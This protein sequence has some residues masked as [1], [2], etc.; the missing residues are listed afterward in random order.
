MEAFFNT[1][2]RW[3]LEEGQELALL[4]L[5]STDEFD[6]LLLCGSVHTRSRD[7]DT[8][9]RRVLLISLGLEALFHKDIEAE[10]AWLRCPR[11]ELGG[12][13][14]LDHMVKGDMVQLMTVAEIVKRER[15]L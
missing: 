14:P 15:G 10:N 5:D 6:G 12:S 9:I 11:A 1:C 13:P 7:H 4:G 8:R 3:R 2:R